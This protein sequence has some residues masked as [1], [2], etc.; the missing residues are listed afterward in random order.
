MFFNFNI[1]PLET[2][3]LQIIC[4][5]IEKMVKDEIIT[6]PLFNMTLVPEGTPPADKATDLTNRFM[7]FQEELKKRGI[8]GGV[9][10]QS[11]L[12]HGYK[13]NEPNPFQHYIG[14]LDEKEADV[15]CPLDPGVQQ[16]FMEVC[17]TIAKAHPSLILIDDDFRLIAR[18]GRGCACP[19][20]LAELEKR[21]GLKLTIP[22]LREQL[23]HDTELQK[24]FDQLQR[25]SLVN[26]AK[27]LRQAID[28]VDPDIAGG[29]CP[30]VSEVRYA[31]DIA[32]AFAGKG[33]PT[34]IRIN[35]GWYNRQGVRGFTESTRYTAMQLAEIREK[36]DIVLCESD[37]CSQNRYS[38]SASILHTHYTCGLLEGCN[39]AKHWVSR[40]RG[41]EWASAKV[42]RKRL[43]DYHNFYLKMHEFGQTVRWQG[44]RTPFPEKFHHSFVAELYPAAKNPW[45]VSLLERFGLPMFFGKKCDGITFM[46]ENEPMGFSDDAMKEILSRSLVLDGAAARCCCERGFSKYIGVDVQEWDLPR[47]TCELLPEG[48]TSPQ[49]NPR[50]LILC[51]AEV[52]SGIYHG[53]YNQ[54][55]DLEY[56]APGVTVFQNELGGTVIVFAGATPSVGISGSAFR[57]E[58]RKKQF[59]RL[60]QKI[61][62]FPVYYPGDTDVY[63]RAGLLP[64]GTQISVII[65][66]GYDQLDSVELVTAKD[67]SRIDMLTP[68][69]EWREVEYTTSGDGKIEVMARLETMMPLVLRFC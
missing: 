29:Y 3:N 48:R 55:N 58:N 1:V 37:T 38:T 10:L 8:S 66:I 12:G 62:K 14:M 52:D 26:L 45:S 65:N 68:A 20:H 18:S 21:T 17:R 42:Y 2:E 69:G 60:L 7:L 23:R 40:L 59:I 13:L 44:L 54:S 67:Y 36:T 5:D 27:M 11:T 50:K 49:E 16:H 47:A 25:D 15:C 53:F 64:D 6:I 57:C 33:K 4:D 30:C 19:L 51:G 28:E 39:G 63:L 35:G 31:H 41:N 32:S 34:I 24:A 61:E 22:E 9:L 46:C 43:R 56:V